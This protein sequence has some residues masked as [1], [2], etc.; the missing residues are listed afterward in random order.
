MP[1]KGLSVDH[2]ADVGGQVGWV[3]HHQ[4]PWRPPS[5]ISITPSAMPSCRHSRRNAEQRW[6]AERKALCTTASAHLLGQRGA[7]HPPWR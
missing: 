7:V 2:R 6:P 1:S 3:A 4:F 5:I